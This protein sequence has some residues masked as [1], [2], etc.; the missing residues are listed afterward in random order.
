MVRPILPSGAQALTPEQMTEDNPSGIGAHIDG[1]T[2]DLHRLKRPR[3]KRSCDACRRRKAKCN[4]DDQQPCSNCRTHGLAC[5][6]LEKRKKR[7][8]ASKNVNSMEERLK[9]M[10]RLV[11]KLSQKHGSQDSE[12][13]E[14]SNDEYEDN[15]TDNGHSN[16]LPTPPKSGQAS[17]STW[18][19]STEFGD[20]LCQR[21][22][23]TIQALSGTNLQESLDQG[24]EELPEGQINKIVTDDLTSQMKTLA[25]EEYD[26]VVYVGPSA[27]VHIFHETFNF[28]RE[29]FEIPGSS[30]RYRLLNDGKGEIALMKRKPIVQKRLPPDPKMPKEQVDRLIE[31]YIHPF[32]PVVN[33]SHFLRQYH[34]N[35]PTPP[36]PALFYTV[37][38]VGARFISP[39]EELVFEDGPIYAP[40]LGAAL[41][42]L[43]DGLIAS[44][45]RKARLSTVQSLLLLS[46]YFEAYSSS[47]EKDCRWDA[48]GE[49]IRMA[50]ELG[51]NRNSSKWRIPRSEVEVRRR[52]WF[53][54]YILDRW[55]GA[56]SGKPL[57]IMDFDFDVELPSPYEID[58]E[59]CSSPFNSPG[60]KKPV[61]QVFIELIR[62]SEVLGHILQAL[63]SPKARI[64]GMLSE[65]TLQTL[66]LRLTRWKMS[67][68]PELQL[69][70]PQL[71]DGAGVVWSSILE[72]AYYTVLLL[73]HRPF[74]ASENDAA[75]SKRAV[76]SQNICLH[77]ANQIITV[78]ESMG[79]IESLCFSFSIYIYTIFQAGLCHMSNVKSKDPEMRA[80]SLEGLRKA[81]RLLEQKASMIIAKKAALV[82]DVLAKMHDVGKTSNASPSEQNATVNPQ[83][84]STTFTPSPNSTSSGTT[85]QSLDTSDINTAQTI[86]L[87]LDLSLMGPD[88]LYK[89]SSQQWLTMPLISPT[90]AYRSREDAQN[91]AP[92]PMNGQ[93]EQRKNTPG[94]GPAYGNFMPYL[95][96][97]AMSDIPVGLNWDEWDMYLSLMEGD[98]QNTS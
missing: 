6:F 36:Q 57:F 49:A 21:A 11:E 92:Q 72:C 60:D 23:I 34:Y 82:L 25:I 54:C 17:C 83:S 32:I 39:D 13:D 70:T 79:K 12:Q 43:A 87:D 85:A 20:N 88:E 40:Q 45:R 95:S 22:A 37:L 58:D 47:D 52:I 16:T 5:T 46:L 61:H 97:N 26:D 8:P 3:A 53:A 28:L 19:K 56:E 55:I 41:Y 74:T 1:S 78:A 89:Q 51:L 50:L 93:V 27:G 71:E 77:A 80:R 30:L 98:K 64:M 65:S 84:Q 33:K 62:V 42:A 59:V 66:H 35:V 69:A 67:L 63:Y 44:E 96:S 31:K 73:L 90:S 4:A 76:Q 9:R 75:E 10:E 24:H 91:L 68:P 18:A 94:F 7:G 29:N 14:S 86:P 48:V 15:D 2:P 81:T 38:A